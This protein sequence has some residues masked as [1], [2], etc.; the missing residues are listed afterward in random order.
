[1]ESAAAVVDW[2][3]V[4]LGMVAQ[5]LE[6]RTVKG[7]RPPSATLKL[8]SL[9]LLGEPQKAVGPFNLVSVPGDVEDPNM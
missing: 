4:S 3:S 1:M 6:S 2:H 9:R 7:S 8:R 5:W